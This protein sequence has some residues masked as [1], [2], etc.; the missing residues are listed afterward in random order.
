MQIYILYKCVAYNNLCVCVCVRACVCALVAIAHQAPLSIGFSRQEYWRGLPV[1]SLD[2]PDPGIKPGSPRLQ[3][4]F[5]PSRPPGKPITIGWSTL[6]NLPLDSYIDS[7]R[8]HLGW[9]RVFLG[10]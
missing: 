5:L 1:P 9:G 4:D 2:L 6:N 7:M 10:T 3:A 8:I